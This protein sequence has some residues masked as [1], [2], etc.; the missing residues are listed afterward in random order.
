MLL[1]FLIEFDSIKISGNFDPL[2][3]DHYETTDSCGCPI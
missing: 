3:A 2:L 1:S